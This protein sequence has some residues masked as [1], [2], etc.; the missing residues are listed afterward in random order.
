MEEVDL[1]EDWIMEKDLMVRGRSLFVTSVTT[2]DTL[3]GI[4]KHLRI[5]MELIK[6]KN[7]PIF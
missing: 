4:A 1:R 3:Q 6:G 5:R 2:L 7:A